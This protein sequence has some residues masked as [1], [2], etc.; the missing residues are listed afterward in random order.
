MKI[1][2]WTYQFIPCPLMSFIILCQRSLKVTGVSSSH[3]GIN[4]PE[5]SKTNRMHKATGTT[6]E[7]ALGDQRNEISHCFPLLLELSRCG[8]S[9]W[10]FIWGPVNYSSGPGSILHCSRKFWTFF[11]SEPPTLVLFSGFKSWSRS[12]SGTSSTSSFEY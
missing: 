1:N 6:L 7:S 2:W 4:T 10:R 3:H 8:D 5:E 9:C 11:F 12:S